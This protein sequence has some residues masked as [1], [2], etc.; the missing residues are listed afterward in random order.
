MSLRERA[1]AELFNEMAALVQHDN[2]TYPVA[3]VEEAAAGGGGG[4]SSSSKKKK[5]DKKQ[6]QQAAAADGA[7]VPKG[8]PLMQ[9][10]LEV[11]CLT[12]E[13]VALGGG[14][15]LAALNCDELAA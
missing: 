9:F 8:P 10:S 15:C 3:S 1:E 7:L 6:Q 12:Q 11:R 4:G 2:V 14:C 5:K 13:F